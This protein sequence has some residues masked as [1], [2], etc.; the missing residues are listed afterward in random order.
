MACNGQRLRRDFPL[1]G[2]TMILL[3][4]PIEGCSPGPKSVDRQVPD[5][6]NQVRPAEPVEPNEIGINLTWLSPGVVG[7]TEEH[8]VQL[9]RGLGSLNDFDL[10]LKVYANHEFVQTYPD[11]CQRWEVITM[12][13]PL[14]A[15]RPLPQLLTKMAR[16][17]FENSW[18]AVVSRGDSFVH[19]LGGSIPLLR[20]SPA[21]VTIHDLQPLDKPEN[22]STTKRLWLRWLLPHSVRSS[23]RTL[24]PSQFTAR[25]VRDRLGVDA[26][27]IEV[28]PYSCPDPTMTSPT[29]VSPAPEILD[30][31]THDGEVAGVVHL[32]SS[33]SSD[34][35][36]TASIDYEVDPFLLYPAIPYAHKRHMDIV[37]TLTLLAPD[38]PH[39]SAVF[40]GRPG[41]QTEA[42]R[43]R[44]ERLGVGDRVH[45]VGRVP[46]AELDWLYD[47][48]LAVVFPSSY[49]GF[50]NPV[51]EAMA[52]GCP[53][54]VSSAGSLPEVVGDAGIVVDVG[55]IREYADAVASLIDKPGL[56]RGLAMKARARFEKVDPGVTAARTA[57]VYREVLSSQG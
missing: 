5:R 25:R 17:L 18:L 55:D 30:L 52:R 14:A 21:I 12:P 19:H 16:V 39:L 40:T 29:T 48:A 46:V 41:P 45:F 47:H 23:L 15:G 36:L 11:I 33:I 43:D 37:E 13:W 53:V 27:R 54:V 44:A 2:L 57:A 9:L 28:V 42:L 56:A 50:G 51:L 7:G 49:E 6:L 1:N 35:G 32:D 8:A 24:C 38:Y 4:N 22:F 34:A 31:P 26:S 20:S 10:N 3:T